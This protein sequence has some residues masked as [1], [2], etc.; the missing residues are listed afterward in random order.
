MSS[1][2]ST[3]IPPKKGSGDCRSDPP[4]AKKFATPEAATFV[5]MPVLDSIYKKNEQPAVFNWTLATARDHFHVYLARG[6]IISKEWH[7]QAY[8]LEII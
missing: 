7:Y 6:L 3:D 4:D 5:G 1:L 8:P 2:F